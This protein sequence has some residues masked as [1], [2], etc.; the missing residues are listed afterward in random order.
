MRA[1]LGDRVLT[2]WL[3]LIGKGAP[4]VPLLDVALTRSG[5]ALV[6]A[7]AKVTDANT[8]CAVCCKQ[9]DPPLY[10]L[11]RALCWFFMCCHHMP[12]L[13]DEVAASQCSASHALDHVPLQALFQFCNS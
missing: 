1:L 8:S 2:P 6:S 5:A 4:E 3:K 7:S 12:F 11:C 10:S 13:Q 9:T